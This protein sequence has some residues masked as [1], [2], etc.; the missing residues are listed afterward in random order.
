MMIGTIGEELT[1]AHWFGSIRMNVLYN[2]KPPR[3]RSGV[4]V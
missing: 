1:F 4:S 2:K 3:A